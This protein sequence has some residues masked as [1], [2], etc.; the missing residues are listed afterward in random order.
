M[1]QPQ[2]PDAQPEAFE[3]PGISGWRT[4]HGGCSRS[5]VVLS[6]RVQRLLA[7]SFCGLKIYGLTASET[8]REG[9]EGPDLKA[10]KLLGTV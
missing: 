9:G 4:A 10:P 3:E 7:S 2:T 6:G 1:L 5:R 8:G